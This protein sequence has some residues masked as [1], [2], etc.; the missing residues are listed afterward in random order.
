MNLKFGGGSF[1]FQENTRTLKLRSLREWISKRFVVEPDWPAL[2]PG[3]NLFFFLPTVWMFLY[4]LQAYV[5][6]WPVHLA[7]LRQLCQFHQG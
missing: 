4:V 5:D 3:L 7:Y 6:C 1:L 2:S